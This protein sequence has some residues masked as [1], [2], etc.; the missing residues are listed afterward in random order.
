MLSNAS[1]IQET[2]YNMTKKQLIKWSAGRDALN[3]IGIGQIPGLCWLLDLP[4]IIM[5]FNYAGPAAIFTLFETIPIIGFFPFFTVAAMMYPNHDAPIDKP[6]TRIVSRC[7]PLLE[8]VQQSPQLYALVDG[9]LVPVM[10]PDQEAM[11]RSPNPMRRLPQ[12][13]DHSRED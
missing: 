13:D 4:L 1:R 6:V 9:R 12:P 11:A 5:H 8:R 3:F 2:D 10:V 7:D